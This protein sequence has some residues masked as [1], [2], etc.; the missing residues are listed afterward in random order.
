MPTTLLAPPTQTATSRAA[1]PTSGKVSDSDRGQVSVFHKLGRVVTRHPVYVVAAWLVVILGAV[2]LGLGS[3]DKWHVKASSQASQLSK[4]YESARAQAVADRAFPQSP[5]SSTATL[6]VTRMDGAALTAADG[7]V[8]AGLPQQL[9]A[10]VADHSIGKKAARTELTTPSVSPNHKV[11]LTTTVFD[12]SADD[13]G[14]AQAVQLLRTA[15]KHDLSGTGLQ[16]RY[17]GDAAGQADNAS[18]ESIIQVVMLG[19]IALLLFV[20]FRSVLVV[21]ISVLSILLVGEAALGMLTIAAHLFHFTL[22]SS[23]TGLLPVVLFGV[24]TDYI[25]FLLFRYREGLRDG[26]DH[27]TAMAGAIGRVGETVVASAFAVAVSFAALLASQLSSFRVL[28]PA[29]GFA[30][31]I[32]LLSGLTLVPALLTMW[33]KR[34]ARRPS[35]T[36]AKSA[37]LA[38]AAGRTVTRRPA[39]VTVV[40]A[41]LLAVL[42]LGLAGMKTSYD[43]NPYRPGSESALGYHDLQTGFPKGALSPVKVYVSAEQGTLSGSALNHYAAE[44]DKLPDVSDATVVALDKSAS[45]AEIDLPLTINPLSTKALDAVRHNIEP[46][47]HNLA[48]TG[49]KALVGGDPATAADVRSALG[50]DEKLI[51]P[52]AGLLIGLVLLLMLRALLAPLYLMASVVLGFAATLGAAVLIYQHLGH[53]A[54]INYQLP[55]IVYLFVSSIGTDYNILIIGRLREELRKGLAPRA[56]ARAALSK[57]GPAAAAAAVI[58]AASFGSLAISPSLRQIGF[59]V[60]VG[61]LMSTFVTAW[62]LIPSLTTVLGRKALWPMRTADRVRSGPSAL[63]AHGAG[64]VGIPALATH[65]RGEAVLVAAAA[66]PNVGGHL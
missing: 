24:G 66:G 62:L 35:W 7:D 52:L 28:G 57:A 9:T 33:G 21:L 10:D 26:E 37:R 56:A 2:A 6:V 51:F 48:P 40:T 4:Q 45:T 18:L 14:T 23:I 15:T 42:A 46:A 25:V 60:A 41:G 36:A 20:L 22:D 27:R 47:A 11:A 50:H 59:S 31:V 64:R 38:E 1:G 58:L 65:Y 5:Q 63:H 32:M 3:A 12:Q 53:Q 54:G 30:V 29:L 55:L 43:Q 61:V 17:T 13:A 16:G 19:L 49:T 34:L 44:L 8:I 39:L